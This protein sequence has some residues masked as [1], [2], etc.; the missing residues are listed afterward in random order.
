MPVLNNAII[1]HNAE[2]QSALL[3]DRSKCWTLNSAT[4]RLIL[5][6]QFP[7]FSG[8]PHI[9]YQHV[10]ICLACLSLSSKIK[11]ANHPIKVANHIAETKNCP[12]QLKQRENQKSSSLRVSWLPCGRFLVASRLGISSNLGFVS[13]WGVTIIQKKW[14]SMRLENEVR[15]CKM[16]LENVVTPSSSGLQFLTIIQWFY[17]ENEVR[18]CKP[19]DLTPTF[20]LS[21]KS[22]M[23]VW[24]TSVDDQLHHWHI[25]CAYVYNYIYTIMC[26]YI[27]NYIHMYR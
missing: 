10:W 19:L 22:H 26:V 14:F 3:S 15:N 6:C 7:R 11:R 4:L 5:V 25:W 16:R 21:T 1:C 12:V 2:S 17:V 8:R 9:K 13:K 18:N 23:I 24:C 20:L 27:Y